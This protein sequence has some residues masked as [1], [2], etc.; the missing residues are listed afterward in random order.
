M[1]QLLDPNT[2][3]VLSSSV[4]LGVSSGVLGS[5]ALLRRRSL[6]GDA[7]AHAALPGIGV[8]FMLAGTKSLPILL[9]G[10]VVAGLRLR[11]TRASKRTP[12]SAL[13]SASFSL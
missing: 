6:L 12:L 1:N 5:F 2:L 10:A 9:L 7:L 13:C 11:A 4:L 8:A 3:W